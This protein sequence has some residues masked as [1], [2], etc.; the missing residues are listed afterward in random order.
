MRKVISFVILA[1]GLVACS[2][3]HI[4]LNEDDAATSAD[5]TLSADAAVSADSSSGREDVAQPVSG[6]SCLN[7]CNDYNKAATCQCDDKCV[8]QGDCCGDYNKQ[9]LLQKP[10]A[11]AGNTAV[12]ADSSSPDTNQPQINCVDNDG[13]GF[14]STSP[15]EGDCNDNDKKINPK[16]LESCAPDGTG[17]GVDENC[18]GTKDEGCKAAVSNPA[19]TTSTSATVK[20]TYPGASYHDLM[21]Y[22]YGSKSDVFSGW[23]KNVVSTG[24]SL[25]LT[26]DVSEFT[27]GLTINVANGAFVATPTVPKADKWICMGNGS[28]ATKDSNA[29]IQVTWG[30]KT[31]GN[32]D[33]IAYP[34]PNNSGCAVV[35]P[36]KTTG[37]CN[38]F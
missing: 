23:T 4:D 21:V 25:E 30:S 35:I 10:T 37:V 15:K 12:D 7:R 6:T 8:A 33:A 3:A 18:N 20:V 14:C 19:P 36:F 17:N 11:D 16:E 24:T 22:T 9:C 27:C 32:S 1:L 2:P 34:T 5:S 29:N 28:S 26:V 31:F 38:L 13:D